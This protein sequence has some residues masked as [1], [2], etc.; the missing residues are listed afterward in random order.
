MRLYFCYSN[1]SVIF[2]C[3]FTARDFAL[4]TLDKQ[5]SAFA[6]WGI[7]ADWHGHIYRTC[8]ADY[9]QNELKIFGDL[10]AKG[11]IY[12]DLKPV[13]WSPSSGTALAEAELEYDNNYVSPSLTLR[14]KIDQPS[15]A[16]SA[17]LSGRESEVYALI[18]TT[19]PWSLPANQAICLNE[20]L[21]YSLVTLENSTA[22][23]LVATSLIGQLP[24]GVAEI[25]ATVKGS[26]LVGSKYRHPIDGTTT[27]HPL[28]AADHVQATK[29]TGLVHM[30]PAHG[31]D[32]FLVGL[33]HRMTLVSVSPIVC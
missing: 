20:S 12:R 30:A 31:P 29:G 10:Y 6:S 16:L 4:S 7:T 24:F 23:H 33:K 5:R 17:A 15:A 1:C 27:D 18:W 13:F 2:F 3:H 19:T 8:D 14:I 25:V 9:V 32:D 11:L 21:E 28:L 22:L 26:D